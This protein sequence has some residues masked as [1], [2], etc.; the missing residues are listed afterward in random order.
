M[1]G[2]RR[3]RAARSL[4]LLLGAA[5][6]ASCGLVSSD[7]TTTS[8]SPPNPYTRYYEKGARALA[9]A[10]RAVH[11]VLPRRSGAPAPTLPAGAFG[12]G[13]GSHQVLGFLPSWEISDAPS[14]DYAALSEVAYYALEVEPGGSLLHS[15][16]GWDD[17]VSGDVSPLVHDA[18]AAGDRALLTLYSGTQSTLA[19]LAAD[20]ASGR[21]LADRA[22]V[23]LTAG[24]FDG[25]DL[26]LEGQ[27]ASARAGFVRF[28]AQFSARLR[29][30]DPTWSIVLNTL[31]QAAVDPESFYDLRALS[32][33]VDDFFV[34]AYDMSDLEVP[35]PTAPLSGAELCDESVLAS[36]SSVVPAGKIILGIP[37][38]GYDFGVN[39]PRSHSVLVGQPFAV[40]YDSIVSI[41]RGP[42]W[43]AQSDTPYVIF[44][45][46]TEWHETFFDD[47][48]SVALKVALAA[49]LHLAGVG[50]WEVGMAAGE[51]AITAALDG[52]SPPLRLGRASEP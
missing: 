18:H 41:D 19:A 11:V 21:A 8:T 23:L 9:E 2:P 6:L 37:F 52:G 44:R 16:Q 3:R 20:P 14:V 26:D 32:P 48:T 40:T 4:L 45:R 24:G 28:M 7:S 35:G 34:M 50:A 1:V 10:T 42:R 43:D 12:R 47:P 29:T 30:I 17:L 13:L 38:Y 22:A 5:L 27:L 33:Y 49:E 25:V 15:G 46:G 51:N 31:P 39:R 36:Y